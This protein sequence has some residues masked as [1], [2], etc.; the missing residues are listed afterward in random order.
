M[1]SLKSFC[2]MVIAVGF[3]EIVKGN[4]SLIQTVEEVG[5]NDKVGGVT[6]TITFTAVRLLS[7]PLIV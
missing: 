1:E 3:A 4:T 7:H 6:L 5:L 2:K